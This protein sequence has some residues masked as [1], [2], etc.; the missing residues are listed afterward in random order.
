MSNKKRSN[1]SSRGLPSSNLDVKMITEI[2]LKCIELAHTHGRSSAEAVGRA[3]EYEQ[4]ILGLSLG[5]ELGQ[6][7]KQS[8][9][10]ED[11]I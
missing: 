7:K 9:K 8:D 3:K 5:K 6:T 10:L 11:L 4:Y 1:Q 2:R